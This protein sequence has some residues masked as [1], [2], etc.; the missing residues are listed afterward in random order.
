MERPESESIRLAMDQAWRDHHHARDQTWKTL[1]FEIALAA[2][3]VAIDTQTANPTATL[4]AGILLILSTLCGMWI[5]LHHR[6]VEIRK[7]THILNC[8]EALGLHAPDLIAGVKLPGPITFWDAFMIW[9]T[10]TALFILRM[11]IAMAL[12]GVLYVVARLNPGV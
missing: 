2:G 9:K 7:F 1:W 12:F 11:H 6:T 3:M 10:N 4:V 8:E 5:T